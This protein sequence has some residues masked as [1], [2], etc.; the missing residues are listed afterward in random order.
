M[1]GGHGRARA[2]VFSAD[3]HHPLQLRGGAPVELCQAH[4][5]V[6]HPRASRLGHA[7]PHARHSRRAFRAGVPHQP[8]SGRQHSA[9][10]A[11]GAA[12]RVCGH[13]PAAHIRIGC[14]GRRYAPPYCRRKSAPR[15]HSRQE[16]PERD[17]HGG[18]QF[19]CRHIPPPR[20][21]GSRLGHARLPG[22]SAA[23]AAAPQHCVRFA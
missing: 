16:H 23:H 19:A 7:Q 22:R 8:A 12:A 3:R 17:E 21:A 11:S 13:P 1:A 9:G 2:A 6:R 15:A 20:L 10:F 4:C 5:S 14:G 18:I